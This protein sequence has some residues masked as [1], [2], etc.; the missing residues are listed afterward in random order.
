MQGEKEHLKADMTRY[1]DGEGLGTSWT[2]YRAWEGRE[3][4]VGCASGPMLSRVELSRFGGLLITLSASGPCSG[5]SGWSQSCLQE[6]HAMARSGSVAGYSIRRGGTRKRVGRIGHEGSVPYFDDEGE[7]ELAREG[8][9]QRPPPPSLLG[10]M[11]LPLP[12]TS[13][14]AYA[15]ALASFANSPL[16]KTLTVSAS[17]TET[18][19]LLL[20]RSRESHVPAADV[21]YLWTSRRLMSTISICLRL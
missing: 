1:E 13:T 19:P 20:V 8:A 18:R 5:Q 3:P 15:N 2:A 17:S 14:R 16:F 6:S 11:L 7:L 21:D 9:L 4:V 10:W 12:F